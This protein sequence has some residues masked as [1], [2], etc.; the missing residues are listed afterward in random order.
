MRPKRRDITVFSISALD[1]FAAALGAFILIVLILFPY[2]Q[3]GGTDTSMEELE[4]LVQRRREAASSL[5]TEMAEIRAIRAEI[6]LLDAQY[7]TAQENMSEIEDTLREVQKLTAEIEIPDP[8]PV[9]KP[10]PIPTPPRSVNRGVEF[11]ILGVGTAKKDIA[12]VVDMSGSMV[13]H[14]SKVVDAINEILD[15]MKPDNRFVIMGYRGGPT[16]DTFPAS[17]RLT[18]ADAP[19]VS[20]AKSYVSG[21]SGRFG[22]GTPTQSAMIRALNLKPEAVILMSDGQPDD[23]RPGT[24]IA[25][26]T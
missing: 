10:K 22:G 3:R 26:I 1:L 25:N 7:R 2:Y 24:I 5:Q 4:E 13:Q 17:G 8:P 14:R 20:R 23:G 18:P 9:P 16:F 19:T 15:Q 21:M 6:R 11:S 12:I